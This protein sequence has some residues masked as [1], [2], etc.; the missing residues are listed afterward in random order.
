MKAKDVIEELA[1]TLASRGEDYGSMYE[2]HERIAVIWTVIL[3]KE[4]TADQVAL[5][6]AGVKMARLI[7]SPN[8]NDSWL[9][10]AGYAAVGAECA[11]ERQQDD[12]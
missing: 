8:H 3:G 10:L 6:M 5:C 1:Q 9:D 2:N 12:S 4:V 11:D 7:Q